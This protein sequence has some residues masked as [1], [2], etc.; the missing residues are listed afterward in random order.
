[1]KKP[2]YWLALDIGGSSVKVALWDGRRIKGM[3]RTE[4]RGASGDGDWIARLVGS[5]LQ[6]WGN[7]SIRSVVA[8]VPSRV[9][10]NH[11][12]IIESANLGWRNYP[13]ASVLRKALR[14]PVYLETDVLL[15]ARV[16]SA[17]G[18]GRNSSNFVY[19]NLGTGISHV[20]M[21]G[22][23][24]QFGAR[25]LGLSLGHTPL[26]SGRALLARQLC[27]CG[28][29]YCAETVLGGR[30]VATALR[31]RHGA[32]LNRFWREYGE[33]LG[34][35]LS[36]V[37]SLVDPERIVLN[38]G[39]CASRALFETGMHTAFR[40]HTL[41]HGSLPKICFSRLRDKAGLIGAGLA[42]QQQT[43]E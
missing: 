18:A 39:V 33:S 42:A 22:G 16:E 40:R 26:F 1:M 17:L 11:R 8:G 3:D 6:A 24:P 35:F 31:R 43:D 5:K 27:T 14:V 15:A 29:R 13:F 34:I 7:P 25:G 20:R 28:R 2:N 37:A 9:D 38:G 12:I 32:E 4:F 30:V 23:K 19:I 41:Y 10:A 21:L 36:C